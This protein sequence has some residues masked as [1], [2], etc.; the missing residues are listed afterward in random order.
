M[1]LEGGW[2]TPDGERGRV[3]VARE[4]QLYEQ[5]SDSATNK[6]ALYDFPWAS[7]LGTYLQPAPVVRPW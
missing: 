1:G 5:T 6:R 2:G 3:G 4:P 7:I